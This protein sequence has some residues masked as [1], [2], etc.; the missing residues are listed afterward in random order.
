MWPIS[1]SD[2]KW[3]FPRCDTNPQNK[4]KTSNTVNTEVIKGKKSVINM[5]ATEGLWF[6]FSLDP[7]T[8]ND[9][10][11]QVLLVLMRSKTSLSLHW[12]P[13]SQ[14]SSM[15]VFFRLVSP[16]SPSS[17]AGLWGM[18]FHMTNKLY[19]FTIIC[20]SIVCTLFIFLVVEESFDP[21]TDLVL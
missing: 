14:L 18:S 7:L 19:H 12:L 10:T 3:S 13:L 4:N 9:T 21:W 8:G 20:V 1:D 6:D 2:L 15:F 16:T 5:E 17:Y 11:P